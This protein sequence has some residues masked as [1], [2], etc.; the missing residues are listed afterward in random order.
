MSVPAHSNFCA[1]NLN[2]VSATIN[3]NIICHMYHTNIPLVYKFY[4]LIMKYITLHN[5]TPFYTTKVN[6]ENEAGYFNTEYG[7]CNKL[8]K[9]DWPKTCHYSKNITIK[10]D[11][12]TIFLPNI[13]F[14]HTE[15][16]FQII[17]IDSFMHFSYLLIYL[18]IHIFHLFIHLL[19]ISH[20][21]NFYYRFIY[22][23]LLNL[24]LWVCICTARYMPWYRCSSPKFVWMGL[25]W[26]K[27]VVYP[28]QIIFSD[29]CTILPILY[30]GYQYISNNFAMLYIRE[31]TVH[32]LWIPD[33]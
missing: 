26:P 31:F 24:L 16:K 30:T 6:Q 9:M 15:L 23:I 13:L 22:I 32:K 28:G 29:F 5:I 25:R 14:F 21:I 3:V 19:L 7:I 12:N 2:H 1:I 11:I 10:G 17:I 33:R 20:S 27:C 4:I 18:F 8:R